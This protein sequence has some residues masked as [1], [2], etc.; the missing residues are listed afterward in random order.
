[1]VSG[2]AFIASATTDPSL[3]PTMVGF[4]SIPATG[5]RDHQ[6]LDKATIGSGGSAGASLSESSGALSATNST[7]SS[8]SQV[9]GVCLPTPGC[10]PLGAPPGKSP[11]HSTADGGASSK[12]RG[13]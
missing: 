9:T 8:F 2:H 5:G 11:A 6:D 3:V 1:M 7:A 12:P 10:T 13:N 4:V